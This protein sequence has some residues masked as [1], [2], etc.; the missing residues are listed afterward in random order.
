MYA[1][2]FLGMANNINFGERLAE[3]RKAKGFTQRELAENIGTSQRMI[4]HYENHVKRPSLDKL[5]SIA[6]AFGL[7]IDQVLGVQPLKKQPGAPKDAYLQRKLQK[8]QALP[9]DDQKV[10]INMID[11]LSTKKGAA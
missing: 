2:Y 5:E 6:K 9:K 10:I 8:V 1:Y 3:L 11:A 4:A 7:S